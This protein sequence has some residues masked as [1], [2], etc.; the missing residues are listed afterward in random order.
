MVMHQ[1]TTAHKDMS[2][3]SQQRHEEK[4]AKRHPKAEVKAEPKSESKSK[5]PA[6]H[7]AKMRE[8]MEM[9]RAHKKVHKEAEG[10]FAREKRQN[11]KTAKEVAG[12]ISQNAGMGVS[13]RLS[14]TRAK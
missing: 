2:K 9:E 5:F 4:M 14:S 1:R 8:K 3:T 6:G 11:L 10:H 13:K 7:A 12:K